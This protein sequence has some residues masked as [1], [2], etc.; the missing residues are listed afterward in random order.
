METDGM[1]S[2]F[3]VYAQTAAE[4]PVATRSDGEMDARTYNEKVGITK[5]VDIYQQA[6]KN[7]ESPDSF[8]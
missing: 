7:R 3:D 6:Q 1:T 2:Q 5:T 8:V 4:P